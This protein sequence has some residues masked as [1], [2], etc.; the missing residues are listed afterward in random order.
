MTKQCTKC[1]KIKEDSEFH[2]KKAGKLN[3]QCKSCHNE[4]VKQH[5][6]KNK[7]Y[8]VDKA[9]R[10]KHEL[11]D[12]FKELKDQLKCE[13]CGEDHPGCLDFHHEDAQEKES[14]VCILVQRCASKDRILAEI[15]KCKVLCAN[16]HRKLHW[17]ENNMPDECDGSTALY[18]SVRRG[19]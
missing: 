9:V 17:E 11:K 14:C 6:L 12:W 19:S 8:Y 16:C 7:K 2:K 3:S 1:L 13:V 18:E 15:S 4:Y 10:W 5:Y